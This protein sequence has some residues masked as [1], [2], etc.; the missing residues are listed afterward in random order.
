MST[1]TAVEDVEAD[2]PD[3]VSIMLIATGVQQYANLF[4]REGC[5]GL[6]QLVQTST[7]VEMGVKRFHAEVIAQEARAKTDV[8]VDCTGHDEGPVVAAQNSEDFRPGSRQVVHAEC[9]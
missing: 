2:L 7:L 6:W 1:R 3:D 8:H 4:K 9:A 5:F